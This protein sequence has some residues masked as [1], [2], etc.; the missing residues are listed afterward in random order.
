MI[1]YAKN[2]IYLLK[3]T[4]FEVQIGSYEEIFKDVVS[5][6]GD[7]LQRAILVSL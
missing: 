6:K 7:L 4:S 5:G 3:E 1:L 2:V